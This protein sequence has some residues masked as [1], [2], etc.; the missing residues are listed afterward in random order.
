[1]Y[2][3]EDNSYWQGTLMQFSGSNAKIFYNLIKQ[4]LVSW[5][6]FSSI[7]LGQ[8]DLYSYRTNK[9]DDKIPV[10]DF[11][12]IC[13][14]KRK[15]T[16]KNVSFEKNFKGLIFKIGSRR[17]NHYSRIYEKRNSF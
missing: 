7:I 14:K 1:M 4:D 6:F 10:P 11:L 8:F 12:E 13:H 17:N 3:V 2:F 5:K 15:K 9:R 16:N